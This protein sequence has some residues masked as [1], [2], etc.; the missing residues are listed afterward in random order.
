MITGHLQ[1]SRVCRWAEE[2]RGERFNYSFIKS[3][4]T[5]TSKIPCGVCGRLEFKNVSDDEWMTYARALP[6]EERGLVFRNL[7]IGD[8]GRI[9]KDHPIEVCQNCDH[10][11]LTSG[12]G[13]DV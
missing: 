11:R 6:D 12:M 4:I 9:I 1:R 13:G 7:P 2:G 8:T 5:M 10:P 3:N